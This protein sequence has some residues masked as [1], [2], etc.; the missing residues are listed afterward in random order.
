MFTVCLVVE[1]KLS[2][3]QNLLCI[4]CIACIVLKHLI[5]QNSANYINNIFDDIF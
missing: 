3:M 1:D 2:V 5:E 4:V